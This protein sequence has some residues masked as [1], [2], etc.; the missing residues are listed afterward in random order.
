MQILIPVGL[1]WSPSY[2]SLQ[3]AVDSAFF[4]LFK[5]IFFG[6]TTRSLTRCA[7]KEVLFVFLLASQARIGIALSHVPSGSSKHPG[8]AFHACIY[9]TAMALP[10]AGNV[11]PPLCLVLSPSVGVGRMLHCS[12]AVRVCLF[13][14]LSSGTLDFL[15]K[16]V[17]SD[18][19]GKGVMGTTKDTEY[20]HSRKLGSAFFLFVFVSSGSSSS[21]LLTNF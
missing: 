14:S 4:F 6:D 11:Q 20:S 1:K 18:V 10:H 9:H 21:A 15:V 13:H 17:D 12:R 8:W 2:N 16:A 3:S 7:I 19:V 5:F